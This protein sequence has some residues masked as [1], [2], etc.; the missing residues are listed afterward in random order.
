M[1]L[2][3][4]NQRVS[5][6]AMCLGVAFAVGGNSEAAPTGP[7]PQIP[8]GGGAPGSFPNTSVSGVNVL[9][10][11][12]RTF[13]GSVEITGLDGQGPIPW[14]VNRYNRGDF[15]LRLAPRDAAAAQGSLGRGFIEF[16]DTSSG[17]PASQA[18]RPQPQ[19]GVIIP[20]ARQNGPIDWGDGEGPFFPTVA[21]SQASSAPGFSMADGT[22]GNG[23]LDINTGRAGTH[24]SSPEANFAFSAAWF[25]FDQGWIGGELTGPDAT[26]GLGNWTRPTA[27]SVGITPRLVRWT[28]FPEGSGVY[29]G[30]AEVQLPGV[31]SLTNGM[32]FAT[33]ADGGSDVNIVGVAPKADGS[34]WVLTVRE[35][36]ATDAET[37]AD[38]GQS[39]FQFLYVPYHARNL[40][41][42]HING[43]DGAKLTARGELNVARTA[44]GVY[45]LTLPGKTGSQGMLI[46]QVA[47]FEPGTSA[48]LASRAFLSYQY[49]DGKFTIQSR[50]TT[51]ARTADLADAD[52]YVAWIDFESPLS[53]PEGPRLRSRPTVAVTADGVLT[54]ESNLAVNT[55]ISQVLVTTIDDQ[56]AGGYL[57]P[58]TGQAAAS[59]VV[60]YFY[61]PVTLSAVGE[62]FIILGNPFGTF[63]RHDV[64]Y[65]PV[66]KQYVVVAN[67][68]SYGPNAT[69]VPLLAL[70]NTNI[71]AGAASPTAKTFAYDETTP[72]NYDDVAIA[73][74]SKN[75]NILFAAEYAVPGEGEGC[76]GVL[77]DKDGNALTPQPG[78][79]DL[80]QGPGDEDDPDLIYIESIDAFLYLVN[81]DMSGGI[82]NRLVGAIVQP[83]PGANGALQTQ[84]EHML[85]DGL[86]AGTTEG[87]ASAI[88]NP[89]NGELLT[90]YD[91]GG[92]NVANGQISFNTIGPAPDYAFTPAR[93]EINYLSGTGGVPFRHN[94]PQLAVDPNSNI[95]VVGH[96]ARQSDVGYPSA[97]VFSLY[98]PNGA[99]LPSQLGTPYFLADALGDIDAGPNLHNVKYSPA[100]DSFLVVYH[101]IPGVTYLTGF[102]VISGGE[103][104]GET[105]TLSAQRVAGGLEISWSSNAAGYVLESTSS[106]RPA[107]WTAV[108]GAPAEVG[109]QFKVTVVPEGAARF[110]RLRR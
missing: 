23:D 24:D 89:F 66:S 102:Q 83:V 1:K 2:I 26:T 60:G 5:C 29:G 17:L 110:Y 107:A 100:S 53:P 32:L 33:S 103:T 10:K 78:R 91:V 96:N 68:R 62:P 22:Y 31:N 51:S 90:A 9:A 20:T 98:D 18:W 87:H 109:G 70:V 38:A 49:A 106:L 54:K 79:L 48:P 67:A 13:D 95:I 40:V 43:S 97:Y 12:G 14:S 57:D 84:T 42:G 15:A 61:N 93:P 73:V 58:I 71:A 75:G 41:G 27:H 37:L 19:F 30:L 64:K 25:P 11:G 59:A 8:E 47:D 76:V 63:T 16:A 21:I 4:R 65:N 86:P 105:P 55:D 3:N 80:L 50:K 39:E 85:A 36:S 99:P 101:T 69:A 46:L 72:N 82:V 88:V 6:W 7:A 35:D 77:F 52:F 28:E 108:P 56:N 81:T 44:A 104:P 92:N 94:H 34:G 45:E 74:S